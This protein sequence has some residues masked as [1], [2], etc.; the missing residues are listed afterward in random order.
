MIIKI[1]TCCVFPV[2][3]E[4]SWILKFHYYSVSQCHQEVF[5]NSAGKFLKSL[6]CWKFSY[7]GSPCLTTIHLV[8]VG[9]TTALKKIDL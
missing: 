3:T 7:M 6:R 2:M 1:I 8:T 5:V 9:V 4:M